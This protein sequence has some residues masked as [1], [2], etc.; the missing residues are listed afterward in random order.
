MFVTKKIAPTDN[1]SER[2]EI[3]FLVPV[4][5]DLANL[6]AKEFAVALQAHFSAAEKISY[7]C[8]CLFGIAGARTNGKDQVTK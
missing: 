7:G 2:F 5:S 6:G 1:P 8:D 3:R 4:A